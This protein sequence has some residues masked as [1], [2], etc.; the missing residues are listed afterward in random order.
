MRRVAVHG[1]TSGHTSVA[2]WRIDAVEIGR[3]KME[4]EW[5]KKKLI[6][7]VEEKRAL[8]EPQHPTISIRRQCTLLGLS[9]ASYYDEPV[10]ADPFTL[11][12]MQRSD[13]QF[14]ETPFYGWPKM[15]AALRQHG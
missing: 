10:P 8:V 15:T 4:L 1:T 5:L 9:R 12:L 14:L 13:R 7:S 2:R 11:E 6:G 3:L